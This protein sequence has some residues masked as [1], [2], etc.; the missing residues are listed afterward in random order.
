MS[1]SHQKTKTRGITQHCLYGLKGSKHCP[2]LHSTI[3]STRYLQQLRRWFFAIFFFL[4]VLAGCSFLCSHW[5]M[6]EPDQIRLKFLRIWAS[7]WLSHKFLWQPSIPTGLKVTHLFPPT[8]SWSGLVCCCCWCHSYCYC[9]FCVAWRGCEEMLSQ[10]P[11]ATRTERLCTLCW[12]GRVMMWR[13]LWGHCSW[14]CTTVT[15]RRSWCSWRQ[16]SPLWIW[17]CDSPAKNKFSMIEQLKQIARSWTMGRFFMDTIQYKLNVH[18]ILDKTTQNPVRECKS[19]V[20][21]VWRE[22]LKWKHCSNYQY[23]RWYN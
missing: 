2:A 4:K 7:G 12:R 1:I 18:Q 6:M 5:W 3:S 22:T 13:R 15:D 10:R 11:S 9:A 19:S 20:K 16:L 17:F 23:L 8:L 14:Q 21:R